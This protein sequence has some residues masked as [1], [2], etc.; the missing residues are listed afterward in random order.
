MNLFFI[1]HAR[2]RMSQRGATEEEVLRVLNK[3]VEVKA[4]KG[5][6]AKELVFDYNREWLGNF[7]PQKKIVV[8]FVEENSE[9]VVITV[10]VYYGNWR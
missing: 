3:G 1:E 2:E 6:K 9:I 7:Y 10:K 5:R 4:K 8:I